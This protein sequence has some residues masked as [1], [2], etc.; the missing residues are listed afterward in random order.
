MP[1]NTAKHVVEQPIQIPEEIPVEEH[2]SPSLHP[3]EQREHEEEHEELEEHDDD[4]IRSHGVAVTS[5]EKDIEAQKK[6]PSLLRTVTS[7]SRRS[8]VKVPRSQRTGLLGRFTIL[9]E[10]EEP[11]DYPRRI[12]WLLT[13]IIAFAAVT[14]AMGSSIILPALPEIEAEFN[15]TPFI[16]NASVAFYMLSMSVFPL[17]WSSFSETAGRRTVYLVSYI[18]YIVFNILAAVSTSISMFIV[19]RVLSGGASASVQAVGAGTVADLWEPRERGKAMNLFYI[20]PLCGPLFAPI[21]GGLLTEGLG[22]R[23]TQWYVSQKI[24]HSLSE[25]KQMSGFRQSMASASL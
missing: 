12:K 19:M 3:E 21:I 1:F 9:Y 20:G 25:L 10:A 7:S 11:K 17:W 18:V 15:S 24:I 4:G 2:E 13:T 14:A 22:W 16:T 6:P 5:P 8:V 23:S